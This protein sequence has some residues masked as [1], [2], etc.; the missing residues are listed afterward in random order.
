VDEDIKNYAD[1]LYQGARMESAATLRE[2]R[3]KTLQQR[4][5]HNSA[6]LPLS[7]VDIQAVMR[8]YDAHIERSMTARFE[9]FKQAYDETGRVPSS[10]DFTDIL[11]QCKQVQAQ[12]IKHAVT[13]INE[14]IRSHGPVSVPTEHIE[15][16]VGSGSAR[17]HDRVLEKWQIWRAKAQLKKTT[18]V[19][20]EE[21]ER[22]RDVL[23]PIYN[24]AE[25]LLDVPAFTSK[26][27]TDV[28]PL[29]LVFMDLDNFSSI[30]DEQGGHE[31]GDRALQALAQ[32]LLK[33]SSGKGCTY[34][35]GGD[36]LCVLL[37]NHSLDEAFAVAERICREVSAI[38]IDE[39][40]KGLRV[41][42]GVACLPE[43]TDDP[44]KLVSLADA[45][46]Y[47]SKKAGGNRVSK[48]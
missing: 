2:D 36:E 39:L 48:A 3:R 15:S 26:S 33:V 5:L 7:G 30:N 13:A 1:T 19:K 17:G 41:S 27:S 11:N 28:S 32:V 42:V 37:P 46:M 20:T 8:L 22:Q 34:R 25:F 24:K 35:Y 47:K 12:E 4:S 14:F 31:I 40:P 21:H 23:L 16:Q 9:S 43:S 6:S 29:G 18:T 44:G 38:K 10:Q 45:A